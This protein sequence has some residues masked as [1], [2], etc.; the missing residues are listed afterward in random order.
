MKVRQS[1]LPVSGSNAAMKPRIPFSPPEAPI[2]IFAVGDHRR[3][4]GVV[5]GL[6]V[7][8]R[9]S[10]HLFAGRGVEGHQHRFGECEIDFVLIERHASIRVVGDHAAARPR[11][12]VPPKK[13]AALNVDGNHLIGR[14]GDEHHSVVYQGRRFV[15]LEI[16]ARKYP[17]R[18]KPRDI[19]GGDLVERA[20][21][22]AIVRAP[23]H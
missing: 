1:S 21:A 15:G 20:V 12:L 3:E 19:G 13:I 6:V 2:R 11:S 16:V 17:D 7:G 23:I 14:R 22:P 9:G 18:P 5:A 10:P 4:G 8:D